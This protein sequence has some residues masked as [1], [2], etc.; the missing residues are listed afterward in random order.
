MDNDTIL[1][2]YGDKLSDK[3][4]EELF[5]VKALKANPSIL[6]NPFAFEKLCYALNGLKPDFG[7]IEPA[8]ILMVSKAIQ[9]ILSILQPKENETLFN[10]EII[11]YIAHIAHEEGWIQLPSILNFA[12]HNLEELNKN[13]KE[14]TEDEQKLQDFKLKAVNKYLES[15][16]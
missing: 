13:K 8:N 5:A 10:H 2:Q 3:Q 6:Q 11:G 15:D 7:I 12:Q 9:K 4:A 16:K 14:L 1:L